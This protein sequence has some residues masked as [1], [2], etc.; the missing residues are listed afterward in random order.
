MK[1]KK[2]YKTPSGR[3][4]AR[5][6]DHY[7]VD[8]NGKRKIVLGSV[9]ADT[10]DAAIREAQKLQNTGKESDSLTV[11][12]VI[13][14]YIKSKE[15]VLSPSTLRAYRSLEKHAYNS[16]SSKTLS[17]LTGTALQVWVSEYS[18]T[19]SPK[20]VR[21]AHALLSSSVKLFDKTIDMSVTLPQKRPPELY[22]PT[23]EDVKNLLTYISGTDL[24]KAVI[25]AA[26]GTLRRGEVCALT[27]DDIS[28]N[29]V[30][31]NK[32]MVELEGGGTA[33]KSP[34]TSQSIRTVTLP[35]EAIAIIMRNHTPGERVV[36]LSPTGIS[37]AFP[38]ALKKAG[39]P[40]FRFHDLR[41]YSAS[42]RHAL[43]IPD[44]YIM[45]EGGWKSDNTLKAIYRR[46][47]ADKE[48]QFEERTSRHFAGLLK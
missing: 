15:A 13:A 2:A 35:P 11:S 4:Q 32:S 27:Y 21:N 23:D 44:Q 12:F 20:A 25:L 22:T 29:T 24:E 16:I 7:E 46:T 42:I 30:R 17:K 40:S 37:N 8:K 45:K 6:V 9:T 5:Y 39:L 48:E 36:K 18:S 38:D 10:A 19:H 47:M 14:N 31:V 26:L 43:G 1:Q 41:A 34:K 28:G 3:W 33:V